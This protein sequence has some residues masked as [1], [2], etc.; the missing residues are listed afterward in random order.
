MITIK[1]KYFNVGWFSQKSEGS[2][3][4]RLPMF[5]E[6]NDKHVIQN[7]SERTENEPKK[8]RERAQIDPDKTE[9]EP[10]AIEEMTF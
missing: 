7:N 10:I 4:V 8:T 2:S 3:A 1:E 6:K 5:Y 9:N